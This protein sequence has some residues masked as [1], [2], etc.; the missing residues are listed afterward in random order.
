[1]TRLSQSAAQRTNPDDSERLASWYTPGLSDAVGDRLLMFDNT[2][3]SSLELLRFRPEFGKAPGF[4]DALRRRV[5]EL[6]HFTHPSVAKVRAVESLGGEDGLAL[7]SNHTVGRRLSEIQ[8]IAQGPQFAT[9]LVTQLVPVLSALQEQSDGMA[10]GLLTPERVIVTPEG[11]LMLTEHVLGSAIQALRLA[12]ARLQDE[13]GL[14]PAERIGV[15]D[16]RADIVQLGYLAVTLL[17]GHRVRSLDAARAIVSQ[18]SHQ[19]PG[20]GRNA[21]PYLKR[22]LGRALDVEGTPFVSANDA[23]RAL[24]DWPEL[25][26]AVDEPFPREVAAP[27]SERQPAAAA[28]PPSKRERIV[29]H[30]VL[31]LREPLP[32]PRVVETPFEQPL[33][34]P[35]VER[36]QQDV[37]TVRQA[38]SPLPQES[39]AEPRAPR[40][41]PA[42]AY[43][44]TQGVAEPEFLP[45]VNEAPARSTFSRAAKPVS[46]RLVAGLGF[47]CLVES[48]IIAGLLASRAQTPVAPEPAPAAD[49]L[50]TAAA[51]AA[52]APTPEPGAS[53]P[54]QRTAA[55]R[56]QAPTQTP[57][58]RAAA[59]AKPA[60][61]APPPAPARGWLTVESPLELQVLEG[62]TLVGTTKGERIML[63]PGSHT[64]RFVSA[65]LDFEAS[66]RVE[67]PAGRGVTTRVPA[68]SGTLSLNALPWAN[69]SL[70]GQ[71]LGT[72]PFA[73]LS[74]PIGTHEV[75]WRHPQ[76]GER[77]QTVVL[78]AKAPVRL[79]V[80]LRR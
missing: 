51:S 75:I 49:T 68:P 3:A 20:H 58:A 25:E 44:P 23:E 47:V 41:E 71:S 78:T 29:M 63:S 28:V 18:L 45:E 57:A 60:A 31:G 13:L 21:P 2:T 70:D 12:P 16:P 40:A 39:P 33:P 10:H 66:V 48:M 37:E 69:V 43:C 53:G 80:D 19:P 27:A 46:R 56:P 36:V 9:E 74:V 65:A 15:D 34:P 22:W 54:T 30:G 77:R 67:V 24:N 26:L 59:T 14:M 79:V 73:N 7:I 76:L 35:A 61:A 32:Q 72:T 52:A 17:V 11:R 55:A 38:P 5:D 6:A 42:R 8:Q 1:M 64:L 50:S 4:E 62:N